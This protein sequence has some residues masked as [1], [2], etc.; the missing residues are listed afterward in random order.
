MCKKN[1]VVIETGDVVCFIGAPCCGKDRVADY[2]TELLRAPF[3]RMTVGDVLASC[4]EEESQQAILTGT[5]APPDQTL[6]H[7]SAHVEENFIAD[8]HHLS[9]FIGLPRDDRD[10]FNILKELANGRPVKMVHFHVHDA[11]LWARFK[12]SVK[13]DGDRRHRRDNDPKTFSGRLSNS[14][15]AEPKIIRRAKQDGIPII[16]VQCQNSSK[17][18]ATHLINYHISSKIRAFGSN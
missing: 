9:L 12:E 17:A 10:Q 2:L 14:R 15:I 4:D 8:E 13:A 11:L 18:V 7:L 3:F 1:R 16:K 6:K 5:L